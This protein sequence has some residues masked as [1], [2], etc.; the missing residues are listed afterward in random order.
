MTN[1]LMTALEQI[2][3]RA[4]YK[5]S[6]QVSD[7]VVKIARDAIAAKKAADAEATAVDAKWARSMIQEAMSLAGKLAEVSRELR[8]TTVQQFEA[9]ALGQAE[10]C[11]TQALHDIKQAV[12]ALDRIEKRLR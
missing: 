9:R 10:R 11:A 8:P 2:I 5:M 3:D 6:S 12:D 1:P 4:E 7:D